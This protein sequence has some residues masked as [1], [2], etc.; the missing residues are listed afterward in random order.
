M[1]IKIWKTEDEFLSNFPFPTA[2]LLINTWLIPPHIFKVCLYLPKFVVSSSHIVK[3]TGN[4]E[5]LEL[6]E[7]THNFGN[8]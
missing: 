2:N 1:T 4:I 8:Q 5:L 7:Q 6:M 3:T